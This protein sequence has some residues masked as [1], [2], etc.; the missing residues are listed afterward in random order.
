MIN[1]DKASIICNKKQYDEAT[2][3]EQIKLGIHLLYCKTCAA[4][5]KKNKKLTVLC[6]KGNLHSLS[7]TEKNAMRE[8][9]QNFI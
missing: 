9:M 3:L 6:E 1:C 7:I 5:S 8:K 2:F 4:F